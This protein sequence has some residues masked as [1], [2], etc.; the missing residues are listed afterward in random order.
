LN[1][2]RAEFQKL[3]SSTLAQN[4]GWMLMGQG[5]GLVLQAGYFVLL[6]RLLGAAE[7]GVY[8]GA[9]ALVAIVGT[10]STLGS[11]TLFLRYVSADK[12]KF[13]IY[14]GNILLTTSVISG[15]MVLL[16]AVVAKHLVNPA[17]ASVVVLAAVSNCFCSQLATCCGQVFQTFEKL[18]ITA[19]LNFLTNFFRLAAAAIMLAW[20]HHASAWQWAWASLAVSL[21]AAIAAVVMV[22]VQFGLPRFMPRLFLS[23]AAEG[24]GYSFA[25]STA[26][27]Y[28]DLDKTMLSHYGMN[29]ANGIY[30]MAYRVVDIATI[31]VLSIRDAAMPRFFREG[32]EGLRKAATLAARLLGR[33]SLLA[34]LAAVV[35]FITAPVLPHILGHGF[36]GSVSALRWLC[37][38][39]LFRSFHQM[40]G[41]AL[42]G[43]GEQ[44]YRTA[45]QLT[46][47]GA[48]FGLNLWLIPTHGWLGAAWA[49]LITDGG[50]GMLNWTILRFL[51]ASSKKS[52]ALE[53]AAL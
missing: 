10:Y 20:L 36:A 44:K 24:F 31:P 46:A 13:S 39:P 32:T 28:N 34:A 29:V 43:A 40:A 17:S 3:R 7:Y 48:N 6:A 45:T 30:T 18:R 16:L 15:V 49:S 11:G 19:T 2:I 53:S 50:L 51:A 33:A 38:I 21:V 4:A 22:T 47:A 35:M 14:W 8:A 42:T 12:T 52:L 27:A 26:S 1:R 23:G 41:S 37:L 9:F 5:L 25:T